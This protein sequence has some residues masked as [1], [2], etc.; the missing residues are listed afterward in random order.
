M[1]YV[2]FDYQ[3]NSLGSCR[4]ID[5]ARRLAGKHALRT[6]GDFS[7]SGYVHIL[8]QGVHVPRSDVAVVTAQFVPVGEYSLKCIAKEIVL[9]NKKFVGY[10]YYTFDAKSGKITW[11]DKSNKKLKE[12]I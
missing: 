3:G 10:K 5:D 9:K 1:E 4:T 7:E 12:Y 2:V 6:Y 8:K 11:V